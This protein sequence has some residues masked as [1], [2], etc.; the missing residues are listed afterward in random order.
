MSNFTFTV[1]Y[2]FLLWSYRVRRRVHLGI[3]IDI[4]EEPTD[5]IFRE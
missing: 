2:K 1:T 3:D 4:S 5:S